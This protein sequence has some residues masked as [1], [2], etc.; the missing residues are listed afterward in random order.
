MH[1]SGVVGENEVAGG[2]EFD[3][4]AE[5]GLSGEGLGPAFEVVVHF[6]ADGNFILRA[7][8]EDAGVVLV[9]DLAGGLGEIFGGPALGSTEGGTRADAY[10]FAFAQSGTAFDAGF[11]GAIKANEEFGGKGV[12]E[13]GAPQEFQ[14]V[15]ALVGRR[16]ARQDGGDAVSEEPAAGVAVEADAAG[17]AGEP[18]G[19]GRVEGV[20]ENDGEVEVTVGERAAE[21]PFFDEIAGA[22]LSAPGDEFVAE[23]L[24]AIKVSHPGHGEQGDARLGKA[25]AQGT[26]RGQRHDGVADPVGGADEDTLVV[27]QALLG[28]H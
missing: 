24:A 13:A 15:E 20:G 14:I 21:A 22:A 25:F 1:G 3:E 6:V 2:E 19:Q 8:Q 10:D 5:G 26:E 12:D 23:G 11:F 28:L 7:E 18:G 9:G 4:F 17:N 27:G 16:V